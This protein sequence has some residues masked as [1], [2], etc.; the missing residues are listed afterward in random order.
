MLRLTGRRAANLGFRR[1][2]ETARGLDC[3]ALGPQDQLRGEHAA[4]ANDAF[5]VGAH[6]R[7]AG[8][9]ALAAE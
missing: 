3:R 7:L 2:H 5:D 4:D 9:P 1:G 8:E 6:A